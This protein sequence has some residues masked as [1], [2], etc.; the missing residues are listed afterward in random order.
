VT[1]PRSAAP[2]RIL[3]RS[4]WFQIHKWIGLLL[5]IVLIPLSLSGSFLVWRDWTDSL[6]N[7]QRYDVVGAAALLPPEA[8]AVAAAK[9]L[10]QDE[11]IASMT[12][13][14]V[15][16][17]PVLVSIAP[18]PAQG[19]PRAGPPRRLQVWLDPT[20]ARV[21]DKGPTMGGLVRFMHD[22]HGSLFIRGTGRTIVGWLGVAM[23]CSA[24]TGLVL[25][26]P[27]GSSFRRGLRWKRGPLTS[28]NLHH[29]VGF[30]ISVPLAILSL[31]GVLISFPVLTGGGGERGRPPASRP[32]SA[33]LAT[34]GE[35]LATA[36]RQ[37]RGARPLTLEWPAENTGQWTVSLQGARGQKRFAVDDRTGEVHERPVQS[38]FIRQLHDGTGYNSLWQ[39][40]IFIS[41]FVPALLGVT[42]VIMWLRTRGWRGDIARRRRAKRAE[43]RT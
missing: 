9:T 5:L 19:P 31:T 23:F 26:W 22:L 14:T 12:F 18:A 25:W 43:A 34:P 36:L 39:T 17:K 16:G 30:W 27:S 3:G 10:G 7:P 6:V 24:L 29:Q 32:S 28:G 2:A 38:R 8:Y 15:S 20:D 33:T 35:V 4:L 11:R 42:G 13:P 1:D 37:D 41:G 40:I 21:L